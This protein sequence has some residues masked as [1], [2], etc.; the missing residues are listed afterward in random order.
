VAL[1][2]TTSEWI[3]LAIAT[4]TFGL[5][6]ATVWLVATTRQ[7]VRETAQQLR[8]E[9]Q[10]LDAAQRP[11]VFPSFPKARQDPQYLPVTNAGAGAALN[12]QGQLKWRRE[13]GG[14]TVNLVPTSLTSGESRGL[15]VDWRGASPLHFVHVSGVLDYEDIAAGRWRTEF[16]IDESGYVRVQL[17]RLMLRPDGVV[18][19][20]DEAQ[21][22][23]AT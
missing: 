19:T 13:D 14:Q 4:G 3:D 8:I 16:V 1:E 18:P 12:I 17:V 15:I 10:R 2:L 6:G 20:G 22:W 9:R 23:R 5:A 11:Y 21:P 7:V